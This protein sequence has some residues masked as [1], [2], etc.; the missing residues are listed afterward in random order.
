MSG[1]DILWVLWIYSRR[2]GNLVVSQNDGTVA[3][4]KY[5]GSESSIHL[6][7]ENKKDVFSHITFMIVINDEIFATS[8]EGIVKILDEDFGVKAEL[9]YTSVRDGIRCLDGDG[10][11]VAIG[12]HKG[13]VTVVD[14]ERPSHKHVRTFLCGL[15]DYTGSTFCD[16]FRSW[17]LLERHGFRLFL[18]LFSN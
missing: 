9:G 5:S 8:T 10:R 17:E 1:K 15:L 14:R 4:L 13:G 16:R 2:N 7:E 3:I 12:H 18:D 11:F 6:E